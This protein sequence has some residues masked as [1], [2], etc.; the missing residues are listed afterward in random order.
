MF[1]IIIVLI[2][3]SSNPSPLSNHRKHNHSL[4]AKPTTIKAPWFRAD[5][6]YNKKNLLFFNLKIY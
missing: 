2:F 1:S 6:K 4:P 3:K 5:L